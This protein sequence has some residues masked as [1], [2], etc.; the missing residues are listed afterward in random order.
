VLVQGGTLDSDDGSSVGKL[1]R[2]VDD[3]EGEVGCQKKEAVPEVELW[4]KQRVDWVMEIP[5]T[6]QFEEFAP[7]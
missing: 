5:G 4:V 3:N 2:G 6:G 7:Y 1:G